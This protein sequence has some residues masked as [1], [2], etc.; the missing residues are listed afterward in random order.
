MVGY[1]AVAT[2]DELQTI[3]DYLTA[4]YGL[5]ASNAAPA[6]ESAGKVDVNKE[7]AAQLEVHLKLTNDE[8]KAV[9]TYRDKNGPFKSIDDL[10]KVPNLD[11]KKIDAKKDSLLFP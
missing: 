1:G 11:T 9:V 10:K 3:L 6:P 7:T 8:A 4:N 2:D 5:Q